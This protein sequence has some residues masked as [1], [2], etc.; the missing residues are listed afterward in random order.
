MSSMLP[1][2]TAAMMPAAT[3]RLTKNPML[4]QLPQ[5][6][7]L[8]SEY[9]TSE[10]QLRQ[11]V[12]Q[13]YADVLQQLGYV[14][15]SG[16]FLPGSVSVNAARQQS[17]LQRQSDLAEQGVTQQSQQEGT[18]F[19]GHRA[20]ATEQAQEP[21]QRQI[22]QL[23]V[24]TPIALGKLYEQAGGLVD[25]YTLQNNLLL[26][27]MAG[28][29][30]AAIAAAPAGS[31]AQQQQGG[32]GDDV[33]LAGPGGEPNMGTNQYGGVNPPVA[34]YT[35]LPSSPTA[36]YTTPITANKTGGSANKKQGIFAVH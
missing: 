6:G 22:A 3:Q 35:P 11:Q 8:D 25:Q 14:D 21:M 4:P 23:G 17:D 10:A 32:G 16:N 13:Q 18:L 33:V 12:A 27:Q 19:S 15:E 28:R 5:T 30:A 20:V 34:A 7:D 29:R 26:A 24:D 36:P 9:M 1:Q 2:P 31:L